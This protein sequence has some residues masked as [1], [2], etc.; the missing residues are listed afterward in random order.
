MKWSACM[1]L[2]LGFF[3]YEEIFF[4]F[5]LEGSFFWLPPDDMTID[6]NIRGKRQCCSLE[7]C[8]IIDDETVVWN[9]GWWYRRG[10][11][12]VV[13]SRNRGFCSLHNTSCSLFL[14][15]LQTGLLYLQTSEAI[16]LY[17]LQYM[18]EYHII[19]FG[20]LCWSLSIPQTV[21]MLTLCASF[22]TSSPK[23]E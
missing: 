14:M 4:F 18:L 20:K 12:T 9:V 2:G 6:V 11:E 17:M 8:F 1:W 22:A 3:M 5:C 10:T 21:S 13:S 16:W 7:Y 23:V 15:S 19:I